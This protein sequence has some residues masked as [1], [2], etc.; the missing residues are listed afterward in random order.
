MK[1]VHMIWALGVGGA[2]SMLVDIV[3]EQSKIEDIHLIIVNQIESASLVNKIDK[4]VVIHRIN[5]KPGSRNLWICLRANTT[6]RQIDPDIIH[7]HNHDLV[8]FF[9]FAKNKKSKLFLTIHDTGMPV[10]NFKKY[11]A[12]FAI[13]DSVKIDIQ[14]RSEF[15]PVTINN[16]IQTDRIKIKNIYSGATFRMLQVGRLHMQK[17]GQDIAL[18]AIHYLVHSKNIRNIS[19]DFIGDGPCEA[20]LMSV[21]ENLKISAFCNFIGLKERDW[22]YEHL[23]DYDLLLQPSRYEGFGLTVAEALAAKVPVLVSNLEGPMEIIG[24]GAYGYFFIT[25]DSFDL[26]NN[27][28]EIQQRYGTNDFFDKIENGYI[29]VLKSYDIKNTALTYLKC[30]Q[31]Q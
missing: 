12:L 13:S 5:R 2:E 19:I 6:L 23:C 14:S 21:S 30:Y 20:Q 17:K 25:E 8:K 24:N 1:V 26:A 27:L 29:N 22:I 7:C 28:L 18:H 10:E 31:N 16:G 4:N 15:S 3:N 9:P 11:S